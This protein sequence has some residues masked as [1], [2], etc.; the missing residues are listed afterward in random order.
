MGEHL[1]AVLYADFPHTVR[2][3]R[4]EGAGAGGRRPWAWVGDPVAKRSAV[5]GY[6]T[7]VDA[8]FPDGEI[9]LRPETYYAPP[10]RAAASRAGLR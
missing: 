7:Q 6:R 8:L 9:P 2:D 10:S 3:P 1:G 5:A 4:A